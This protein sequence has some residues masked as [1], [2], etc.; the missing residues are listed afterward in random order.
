MSTAFPLVEA[1]KSGW[2]SCIFRLVDRKKNIFPCQEL[3]RD[4]HHQAHCQITRVKYYMYKLKIYFDQ[5]ENL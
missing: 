3:K 4:F 5:R 1:T 2:V